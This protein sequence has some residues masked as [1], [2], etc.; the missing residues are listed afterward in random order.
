MMADLGF[1]KKDVKG[2]LWLAA[3]PM[4]LGGTTGSIAMLG[5]MP[6]VAAFLKAGGDDRDPEKWFHDTLRELI[7]DEGEKV[8]R[9][10]AF[11]A[12]GMDMSGSLGLHIGAPR[13]LKDLT[14]PF[15][16]VWGDIETAGEYIRSDQYGR[17]AE[18][19]APNL[20]RNALAAV[21]ELDGA[22]TANGRRVWDEKG[23]P[24]VPGGYEI[25]LKAVGA[26]SANRALLQTREWE[27]RR[28]GERFRN[29]RDIVYDMLRADI[30]R[31]DPERRRK[32]FDRIRRYNQTLVDKGL[33]GKIPFITR[34]SI[35]KQYRLMSR[36]S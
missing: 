22:V 13:S 4:F 32:I 12:M 35:Q 18:V 27:E 20:L 3:A 2:A 6:L 16:G 15:G 26:R 14:G 9:Y 17:A 5:I 34:Q 21:R 19:L 23:R 1:R 24:Y 31:P 25:V 33:A 30:Y 29:Q 7:G 36:P 10:G 11:G 8:V 28:E